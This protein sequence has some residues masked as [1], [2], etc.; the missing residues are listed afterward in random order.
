MQTGI[1]VA[2]MKSA[3]ASA[4]RIA[5][6]VEANDEARGHEHAG[7]IDPVHALGQIAA[8]VLLLLG[9]D[10]SVFGVGAFD[11][12]EDGEEIRL[13]HQRSSSSSSAMLIEASVENSNG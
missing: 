10:T 8:G 7:A 3:I 4:T 12:D 13:A 9:I 2:S 6:A 5:L 11:A 1:A